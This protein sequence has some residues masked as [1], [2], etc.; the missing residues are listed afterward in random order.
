MLDRGVCVWSSSRVPTLLIVFGKPV[1]VM[2]VSH[3]KPAAGQGCGAP[4]RPA[5][6]LA[7]ATA[8]QVECSP[9]HHN[10]HRCK[11]L[12]LGRLLQPLSI[13]RSGDLGVKAVLGPG[14]PCE[15]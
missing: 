2:S 8:S 12:H 3:G 14:D 15:A 11:A 1:P 9:C 13:D 10:L 7:P 4:P 5:P 6:C